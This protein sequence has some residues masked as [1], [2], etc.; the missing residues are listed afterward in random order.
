M[1]FF[2][3]PLDHILDRNFPV[4]WGRMGVDGVEVR[5]RPRRLAYLRPEQGHLRCG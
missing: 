1:W 2:F 4:R 5:A 3:K